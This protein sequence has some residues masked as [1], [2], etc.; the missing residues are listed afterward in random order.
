[1]PDTSSER[2]AAAAAGAAAA[3]VGAAAIAARTAAAPNAR[4]GAS[5]AARATGDGRRSATVATD[6]GSP[7]PRRREGALEILL[8]LRRR[9]V[10]ILGGLRHRPQ[11]DAIGLGRQRARR[12][13]VARRNDVV[14]EVLRQHAHRRRRVER[15]HAG[16][17][18][19]ERR[20][21]AVD[22]GARVERLAAHLL[23][24]HV[25]RRADHL[26]ARADRALGGAAL[27]QLREPEVEHLRVLDASRRRTTIRFS[28]LRSR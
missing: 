4:V 28:G 3:G 5:P 13:A 27:A 2:A 6:V 22:V 1:M 9:R 23:G 25:V 24:R 12:R 17:H 21:E 8:H 7:P 14:G 18:A 15:R 10:A 20:A 16:Q 26:P 19:V 11:H